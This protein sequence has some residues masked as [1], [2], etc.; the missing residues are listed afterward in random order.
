M[1]TLIVDKSTVRGDRKNNLLSHGEHKIF[2]RYTKSERDTRVTRHVYF[3]TTAIPNGLSTIIR[4]QTPKPIE[5]RKRF[6]AQPRTCQCHK[7]HKAINWSKPRRLVELAVLRSMRHIL[8]S[9]CWVSLAMC[10]LETTALR[11]SCG[12]TLPGV[13]KNYTALDGINNHTYI[14]RE[15]R[16]ANYNSNATP[17]QRSLHNNHWT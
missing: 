16:T 9:H 8:P 10:L 4:Y 6:V 1:I 5:V 12:A 17:N 15:W 7:M 14:R 11:H 13:R 2:Y 3:V